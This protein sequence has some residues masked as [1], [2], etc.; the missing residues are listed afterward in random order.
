MF[1]HFSKVSF[2]RKATGLPFWVDKVT[3]TY[4]AESRNHRGFGVSPT[5]G[6]A[7][8]DPNPI[9]ILSRERTLGLVVKLMDRKD[10]MTSL[11]TFESIT[12]LY[13]LRK[14]NKFIT[15]IATIR[16]I[17]YLKIHDFDS[18]DLVAIILSQLFLGE[19]V[20]CTSLLCFNLK[21]LTQR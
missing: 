20:L 14:S 16:I 13:R 6:T 10:S 11:M 1:W 12:E 3:I 21:T 5:D 7:I 2:F 15:C 8:I 9:I 4:D 18:L 19:I 17:I